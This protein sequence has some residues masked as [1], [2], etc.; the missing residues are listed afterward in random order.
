MRFSRREFTKTGLSAGVV[1]ALGA[2]NSVAGPGDLI[3]REI[4]SLDSARIATAPTFQQLR[5][6]H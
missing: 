6:N 2:Q 1:L 4:P 3:L 5:A